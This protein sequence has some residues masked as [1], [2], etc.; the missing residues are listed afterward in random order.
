[1]YTPLQILAN[2]IRLPSVSLIS[3]ALLHSLL[4]S[5]VSFLQLVH[6]ADQFT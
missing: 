6:D 3:A 5:L 1:M 4:L 2:T